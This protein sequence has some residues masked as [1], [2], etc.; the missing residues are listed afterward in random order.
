L[1]T[2]LYGLATI[3]AFKAEDEF[4]KQFDDHQDLHSSTWYGVHVNAPKF[5][6]ATVTFSFMFGS[7]GKIKKSHDFNYGGSIAVFNPSLAGGGAEVGLAISSVLLLSG[8]FQ[9]GVRQSAE[10]EN[11]MVSV[12]RIMD[13]TKLEPE[14][15]LESA[16]GVYLGLEPRYH[17]YCTT[18]YCI[19]S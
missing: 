13:Y 5:F 1:S 11:Q 2:S 18:Y 9:W 3:R 17:T 8:M 6:I 16:E 14:A 7:N 12:E 10:V 15:P 4:I 19:T